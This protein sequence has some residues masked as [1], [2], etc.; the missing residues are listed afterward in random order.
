MLFSAIASNL[1][2]LN[3]L[4]FW[5]TK[6]AHRHHIN[7]MHWPIVPATLT[8]ITIIVSL[9]VQIPAEVICVLLLWGVHLFLDMFGILSGVHL[10]MP[11]NHKEFAFFKIYRDE[12]PTKKEVAE[13]TFK[14]GR[15]FLE[16]A[17]I[18]GAIAYL[19]L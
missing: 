4:W 14:S 7:F 19:V 2:D 8:L 3:S 16:I 15:L 12:T 6:P 11:F 1:M 5:R 9:F 10:L 18:L 13:K 17:I